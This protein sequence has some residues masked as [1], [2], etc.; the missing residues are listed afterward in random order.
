[1]G[2]VPKAP[3]APILKPAKLSAKRKR[4]LVNMRARLIEASKYPWEW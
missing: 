3:K 2:K 4:R 1:M